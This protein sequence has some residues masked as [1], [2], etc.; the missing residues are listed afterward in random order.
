MVT[1]VEVNPSL[2]AWAQERSATGGESFDKKFP[3]LDEWL[4][5][6]AKPTLRQ[7]EA[8]AKATHTPL[9]YL[10]LPEPPVE[11]LPIP[12]LRTMQSEQLERPSPELLDTVYLCQ[13]RQNR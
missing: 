7:L 9:G 4:K 1:R 8:F 5:G 11:E 10:F 6:N 13:R 3:K 12:D 2:L